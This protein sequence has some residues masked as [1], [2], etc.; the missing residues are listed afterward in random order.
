MTASGRVSG[1]AMGFALVVLTAAGWGVG[2]TVFKH[3]IAAWPPLFA[4]GSAGLLG[5]AC[6][7]AVAWRSGRSLHVPRALWLRLGLAAFLNVFVW[8]GFTALS[9]RWLQVSEGTLLTYTMPL[10]ASL[11]A[12]L[13]LH[14]RLGPRDLA[15]LLL[16]FGGVVV[17]VAG[18]GLAALGTKLPGVALALAAALLFACGSVRAKTPLPLAP[19]VAT[20]WQVGLGS[21]AMVAA[22]LA[23][24]RPTLHVLAP[25]QL[26]A[27]LYVATVPMAL[28]YLSWFAALQRLPASTA[29][30][31]SLLVPVIGTATAAWWLRE[32]LGPAVYAAFAMV[33]GGVLLA[34]AR[35]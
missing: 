15:G 5:A 3:L 34:L 8:M 13:L 18:P 27:L 30:M 31:G 20:A 14:E 7:A 9:L 10:W 32:P 2:W 21:L 29:A 28:C 33:L 23:L 17:L 6:L 16:G 26:V 22:S 19:V 25:T 12:W 11:L 35:R 1:R 24:E 4:R